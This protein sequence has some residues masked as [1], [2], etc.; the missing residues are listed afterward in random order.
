VGLQFPLSLQEQNIGLLAVD[1]SLPNSPGL[2]DA[3]P[4]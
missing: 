2:T 1:T 4:I 3:S